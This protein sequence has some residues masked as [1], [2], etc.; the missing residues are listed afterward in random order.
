M[1]NKKI[2][3]HHK[4][5]FKQ[6]GH[7]FE[8]LIDIHEI[9]PTNLKYTY[10]Q[11]NYR[12]R[13]DRIYTRE[14]NIQIIIKYNIIPS[15]FSDHD[16]V[17]I[18]IKWGN[19][20]KWGKGCWKLN[21]NILND[22]EYKKRIADDLFIYKLNKPFYDTME[23]WDIFKKQVKQ[24]TIEYTNY[25]NS[26]KKNEKENIA[27]QLKEIKELIDHSDNIDEEIIE[28]KEN[29]EQKLEKFETEQREGERIRAKIEKIQY[30]ERSTKYYYQ[31]EKERG[32]NKQILIINNERDEELGEKEEILQE[33]ENFY[34]KLYKSEGACEQQMEDNLTH[35]KNKLTE[36]Q[37]KEINEYIK[38]KEIYKALIEMKNEKSPGE[39]GLPKEFYVTFFEE[40]KDILVELYNNI[41]YPRNNQNHK[42]MQ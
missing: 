7:H 38:E 23:G 36:Q 25:K 13:L 37:Q 30:D 34:T 39:D 41:N 28:R 27:Q 11:K 16:Q 10:T 32:Q 35:V 21:T 18:D 3:S 22:E 19:N 4:Q 29:I 20:P 9:M 14:D 17:K 42:K 15:S 12:A 31:R 33:I 1:C 5:K 8:D 40:L 26:T 6:I 2:N 24:T